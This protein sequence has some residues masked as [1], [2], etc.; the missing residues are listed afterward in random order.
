ML[1]TYV[2]PNDRADVTQLFSRLFLFVYFNHQ[3]KSGKGP[4]NRADILL[5]ALNDLMNT[6]FNKPIDKNLICA[7][8]LLKVSNPLLFIHRFHF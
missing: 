4:P 2:F 6:L 1:L 7:V 5:S 3:V 8:K